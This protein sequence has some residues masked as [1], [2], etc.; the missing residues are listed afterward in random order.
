MKRSSNR[1]RTISILLILT[2]VFGS[3]IYVAADNAVNS[4][5][6]AE[7]SELSVTETTE[8]GVTETTEI[9]L[10]ETTE[11]VIGVD[12]STTEKEEETLPAE[13]ETASDSETEESAD[14]DGEDASADVT[15]GQPVKSDE[16]AAEDDREIPE[17]TKAEEQAETKESVTGSEEETP[18]E[19][20]SGNATFTV[21]TETNK[22]TVRIEKFKST[23]PVSG[24]QVKVWSN[25]KGDDDARWLTLKSSATGATW[26]ASSYVKDFKN[27]GAAIAEFYLEK[28]DGSTELFATK[29]LNLK[30]PAAK[31]VKATV[32]SKKSSITVKAAGLESELALDSVQAIVWTKNDK[33]DA[34]TYDME[35]SGTT[36]VYKD[37][38]AAEFGNVSGTY[39][40]RVLANVKNGTSKELLNTTAEIAASNGVFSYADNYGTTIKTREKSYKLKIKGLAREGGISKVEFEL[41]SVGSYDARKTYTAEYSEDGYYFTDIRIRDFRKTGQYKARVY[42][43]DAEGNR[44]AVRT[45]SVMNITAEAG[46]TVVKKS[47]NPEKGTFVLS[48]SGF[49]SP[50]G[51]KSI[52]FGVW[53]Q[54]DKSDKYFYAATK[55]SDGSYQIT[56]KISNHDYNDGTFYVRPI[57]TM[58]NYTEQIQSAVKISFKAQNIVFVKDTGNGR[59]IV[60]ITGP[61]STSNVKFA[62]WGNTN[63]QNDLV[64]YTAKKSGRKYTAEVVLYDHGET[65]TYNVHAYSGDTILGTKTFKVVSSDL[66][67]N[68]Y[69]YENGLKMYYVDGVLQTNYRAK[70]AGPYQIRVN[71]VSN[72]VTV[73]AKDGDNGFI[74]PISYFPC[75]VGTSDYPSPLG[76]FHL[77]SRMRWKY[78]YT[79]DSYAQYGVT[80]SPGRFIHS[81]TGS[82]ASIYALNPAAYNMLGSP[83]SHGC[84]RL[85][86]ID[87]KWV[88][89]N[90]SSVSELVIYDR[91][92]PGPFGKA[93]HTSIPLDQH[94]DPTDPAIT[95]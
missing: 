73:Y 89:D 41:W 55:K 87:A 1:A 72:T 20:V 10:T 70:V 81:V 16:A 11:T 50:S 45:K 42:V 67:K 26:W 74:Q 5:E 34:K 4:E 2:L 28:E 60:G 39:H 66:K 47:E 33:S 3:T 12:E 24:I 14:P 54:S 44:I 79:W 51:I 25:V 21:N 22:Y 78:F 91:S 23:D 48:M 6:I 63:G 53:T 94:Y 68:G 57:I 88:Y 9:S 83:A 85:R 37:I 7:T 61:T 18:E 75:S 29:K 40:V 8:A 93:P 30:A 32:N 13:E 90:V 17:E 35:A 92:N 46:G 76:T 15:E 64:W 95:G 27:Y 86:V 56:V 49:T 19:A 62:V 43:T 84:I 71:R 38:F 80:Y 65:G 82:A 69:F 36:Y 59:R 58:G 31:T 77:T 52:R